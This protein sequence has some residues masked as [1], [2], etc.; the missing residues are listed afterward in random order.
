MSNH[1]TEINRENNLDNIYQDLL[2][3]RKKVRLFSPFLRPET[4]EELYRWAEEIEQREWLAR[5][6]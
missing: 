4:D 6:D 5:D 1:Y 3:Q 2:E